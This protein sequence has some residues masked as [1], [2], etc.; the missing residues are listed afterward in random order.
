MK[1][2]EFNVQIASDKQKVWNT[3]LQ[4]ESYE[5]WAGAA[6]PGSSYEGEWA[7]GKNLKFISPGQGGTMATLLE[8]NPYEFTL[9]KH[10]ALINPDGSED[11]ES[12]TAKG[13][14]GT[15]ESYTFTEQNG[16]TALK[17]VIETFPAWEKMFTDDWPKALQKLKEI[18]EQ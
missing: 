3:M 10:I 17:V 15:T 18:C 16:G 9:A 11:R 7:K 2:L 13:W 5:V 14:I 4:L 6:W 8:H 12:D 1:Q